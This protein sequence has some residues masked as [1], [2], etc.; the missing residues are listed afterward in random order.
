[1]LTVRVKGFTAEAVILTP[2]R[3][4][5]NERRGPAGTATPPEATRTSEYKTTQNYP[6][7]LLPPPTIDRTSVRHAVYLSGWMYRS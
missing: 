1:M 7:L 6:L 5:I 3:R 2:R 4:A